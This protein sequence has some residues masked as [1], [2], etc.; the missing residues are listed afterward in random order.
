MATSSDS[1]S[2]SFDAVPKNEKPKSSNYVSK[3]ARESALQISL[4]P[5]DLPRVMKNDDGNDEIIQK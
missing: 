2:D 1:E 3:S 5:R 4:A